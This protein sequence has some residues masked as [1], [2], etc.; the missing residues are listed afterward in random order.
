MTHPFLSIIIPAHNEEVRLPHSLE[1]VYAFLNE[2]PYTSEVVV[3][4][5]GS[6]DQTFLVGQ[7]FA[8]HVD[9]LRIIHL[10][11]SGKGLAIRNGI[12]ASSGQ[13]RFIA[14]ADFSMPV[15]E[16]NLFLPPACDYDIAIASRE[17]PGA[18]RYNE[19]SFRHFIGRVFN[20]L[21][22]LLVIPGLHDTQCGFKCF[23]GDVAEDIFSYQSLNGWSFDVEVLHVARMHGWQITEIPIHWYYFP[24][25]KVNILRDSVRMFVELLTIHRNARRGDYDRKS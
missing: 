4:E 14:D 25:S 12:F 11:E 15:E 2:Q 1:Q 8:R 21:I 19:P 20:L 5:N 23:R 3:V 16:I 18:I 7:E 13:Y 22:R 9:N 10:D 6:H 17:A 24:G